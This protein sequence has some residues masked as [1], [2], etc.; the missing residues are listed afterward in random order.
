MAMFFPREDVKRLHQ[1]LLAPLEACYVPTV[2]PKAA[3]SSCRNRCGKGPGF[4]GFFWAFPSPSSSNRE[5][6]PPGK[7]GGR[8]CGFEGCFYR[9]PGQ[10]VC[11]GGPGGNLWFFKCF[12]NTG[13]LR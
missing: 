3:K 6:E 12:E 9:G 11:T 7:R 1:Q 10:T 13:D 2:H 5:F 4:V 8:T